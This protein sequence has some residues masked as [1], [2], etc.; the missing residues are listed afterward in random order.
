MGSTRKGRDIDAALR[1][2]GF[3]CD[4]SGDHIY[5]YFGDSRVKTKMSH[6]M[7]SSSLSAELIGN[8]AR[9]LHITKKQFL[10]LIDCPLDEAGYRAILQDIGLI[11]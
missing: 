7:G 9:Q 5:Y 8:M 6:G 1:K 3:H 2:K 10:A 11:S 4:V